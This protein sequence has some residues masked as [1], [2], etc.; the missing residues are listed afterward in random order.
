MRAEGHDEGSVA[1]AMGWV[2]RREELLRGGIPT[3]AT[4]S[5]SKPSSRR[6]RGSRRCRCRYDTVEM[7]GFVR[8]IL[9]FDPIEVLPERWMPRA[10]PLRR[11]R[12]RDPG[13]SQPARVRRAP[14]GGPPPRIH[15]VPRRRPRAV[16]RRPPGGRAAGGAARAGVPGDGDGVPGGAPRRCRAPAPRTLP[17]A[18]PVAV[19][20]ERSGQLRRTGTRDRC[21]SSTSPAAIRS[22]SFGE[23]RGALVHERARPPARRVSAPDDRTDSHHPQQ[24]RRVPPTIDVACRRGR[25]HGGR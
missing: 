13:A 17:S 25:A 11:R 14:A 7:L 5:T 3:R 18:S 15:R 24:R 1:E 20:R 8:G 21:A 6:G 9:D 16:H 19:Q 10:R 12:H 2:Q 4:S 23:V 22:P